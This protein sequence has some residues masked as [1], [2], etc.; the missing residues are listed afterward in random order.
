MNNRIPSAFFIQLPA[1]QIQQ[2]VFREK[3][4]SVIVNG[5]SGVQKG[6]VPNLVF[7]IFRYKVVIFE[8][9]NIRREGDLCSPTVRGWLH[10][11]VHYQNALFELSY[12]SRSVPE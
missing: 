1:Y 12:F 5:Q 2:S 7:Q 11:F 6:I 8:N 3:F 4:L 9:G 10:I